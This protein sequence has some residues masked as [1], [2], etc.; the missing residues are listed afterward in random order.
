MELSRLGFT[1][2]IL[3]RELSLEQISRIRAAIPES[4]ELEAFVHGAL[5][6]CYSGDCYLSEY[7]T[8]RSANRGECAQPCRSK[9]D[10]KD[11]D[12]NILI[13]G[14]PLLSLKDLELIRDIPKLAGAGIVSFKIEGRLKNESYVKNVTRAYSRALDSFIASHPDEYCR[15]SFGIVK[16]GFVPN[17]DKTFN[18]G[19]TSLFIDG[20][21]G[22]WNS[23]DYAKGMGEYLGRIKSVEK[24]GQMCVLELNGSKTVNNGDGLCCVVNGEVEGLRADKVE[25][26]RIFCKGVSALVEGMDI[27]RNR[28][29]V[30]ERELERNEPTRF[31]RAIVDVEIGDKG[32]II[33]STCENGSVAETA[34]GTRGVPVAENQER[35][36]KL[37]LEQL[38]KSS[39]DYTFTV[40]D[41]KGCAA[42]PLLSAAALNSARREIAGILAGTASGTAPAKDNS[43]LPAC[44]GNLTHP[45]RKGELMRTRYC[46]LAELGKCLKTPEGREFA[47]KGLFLENNGRSIPLSF[48]CKACEMVLV[49]NK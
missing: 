36:R 38:G 47:G 34:I 13:S 25:N 35:M 10:L 17:L 44:S 31:L 43:P 22:G 19:Y 9:Y 4:I 40:R 28:D 20:T 45:R 42:L 3:E 41:M 30:F 1:R 15:A 48:D 46:L 18:R 33:R 24:R 39:G 27:W 37:I 2:L 12:G 6:V 21:R 8:G 32:M 23:G 26:G 16:G 7:L 49:E 11:A 14:R 5:C 29:I